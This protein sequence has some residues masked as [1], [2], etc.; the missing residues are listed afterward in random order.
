MT[1]L[2]VINDDGQ[3]LCQVDAETGAVVN[4]IPGRER[5]LIHHM[6]QALASQRR[7][8]IDLRN[9]LAGTQQQCLAMREDLRELAT[10]HGI[11]P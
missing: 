3:V 1:T 5:E 10:K 7:H 11:K 9:G 4:I 6:G 8:M 2:E